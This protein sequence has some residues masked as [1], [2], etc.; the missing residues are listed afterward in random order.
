MEVLFNVHAVTCKNIR[1]TTDYWRYIIEVKHPESFR[2]I[3]EKAAEM[4]M[5]TLSN[6]EVVVRE[7][8]DPSVYLYYRRFLEYFICVVAKHLNGDGYI[9]TSYK[10]DQVKKGEVVW[11]R[12]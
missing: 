8:L 4:A 6:P 7:K 2:S 3:A 11:R 1:T 5:E 10:T 9:I 12:K